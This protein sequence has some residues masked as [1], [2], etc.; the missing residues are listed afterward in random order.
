MPL[1]VSRGYSSLSYLH[2]AAMQ[3]AEIDKPTY[4]YYFGDYDPSGRDIPRDIETKLRIFASDA[5][6]NFQIVG[7]TPE[8]IELLNLQTRP[9][10]TTDTLC[11]NFEGESVEVDAIPP[12]ILSSMVKQVFERHIDKRQLQQSRLI[13]RQEREVIINVARSFR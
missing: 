2:G 6:I 10:K 7:V 8:K 11:K 9:T 3:I 1:M 4:I 12:R 5:D 13:E